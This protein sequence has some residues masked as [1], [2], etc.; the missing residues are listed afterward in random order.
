LRPIVILN[1][2]PPMKSAPEPRSPVLEPRV[3]TRVVRDTVAALLRESR[4]INSG[5]RRRRLS[6]LTVAVN[7]AAKRRMALTRTVLHQLMDKSGKKCP[8]SFN[9][10]TVAALLAFVGEAR[11]RT[12]LMAL[13]GRILP[14][15]PPLTDHARAILMA[16]N[17]W[18]GKALSEH[19]ELL[20]A[21]L[22]AEPAWAALIEAWW[23]EQ[24]AL[25]HGPEELQY[26]LRTL[27]EEWLR[28][29][30]DDLLAITELDWNELTWTERDA[31]LR[32]HLV[33]HRIRLT[34][35]PSAERIA[36]LAHP[37]DRGNGGPEFKD[38][39]L[40]LKGRRVFAPSVY[41]EPGAKRRQ[42]RFDE[43]RRAT[44]T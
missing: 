36:R 10:E 41:D 5:S 35:T 18:K 3:V 43:R 14:D 19:A 44:G 24:R 12:L 21:E 31:V 34:R 22:Y 40:K 9:A 29:H 16:L 37:T 1:A 30:P 13:D 7:Y 11:R 32:A 27:A 20:V 15:P 33:R 26:T 38:R 42:R 8:G 4:R 39:A 28:D 25:G 2:D 23:D 17:T 6:P